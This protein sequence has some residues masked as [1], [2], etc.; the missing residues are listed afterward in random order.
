MTARFDLIGLVVADMARSLT[1]YRRLGLEV[2]A[3]ADTEPHIEA[4]A[5]GVP[6]RSA[7]LRCHVRARNAVVRRKASG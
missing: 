2:P 7:R 1:F 3:E 6:R 5:P 4:E